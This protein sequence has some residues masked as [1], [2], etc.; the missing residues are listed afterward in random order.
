MIIPRHVGPFLAFLAGVPAVVALAM[1]SMTGRCSLVPG[2]FPGRGPESVLFLAVPTP[3]TLKAGPGAVVQGEGGGHSGNG[4]REAI[5][6]QRYRVVRAAGRGLLDSPAAPPEV[7][8]VPWDYDAGC[9][10]VP[11]ARTARWMMTDDTVLIRADRRDPED[12]AG[13]VPTFDVTAVPQAVY[14]GERWQA[15]GERL[16]YS[17]EADSGTPPPPVNSPEEL[18]EFL[19]RLPDPDAI[20]RGDET[21]LDTIQTW[22]FRHDSIARHQPARRMLAALRVDVRT[23]RLMRA[24]VPMRGTWRLRIELRSGTELTLWLRTEERPFAPDDRAWPDDLPGPTGYKLDFQF[25]SGGSTPPEVEWVPGTW[26]LTIETSDPESERAWRFGMEFAE[27]LSTHPES[28]ALKS[29]HHAW[30]ERMRPLW[31]AGKGFDELPGQIALTPNGGAVLRIGWDS[32]G[33]GLD[34]VVVR[35]E[36]VSME[37]V[38]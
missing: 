29:L 36:R 21:V 10:P 33:D 31:S 4:R 32:D 27:F 37:V 24:P 5:Y 23:A 22:A 20:R 34:D 19:L 38:P 9:A 16:L 18:F 2:F 7:V 3:D 15:L 12:W 26:Y 1:P 11:W 8:L 13:E 6:G 30:V 28:A 14:T 25:A 35:G 17:A